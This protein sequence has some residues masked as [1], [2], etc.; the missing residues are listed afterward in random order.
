MKMWALVVVVFV[1][2]ITASQAGKANH[3]HYELVP[4]VIAELDGESINSGGGWYSSENIAA[5]ARGMIGQTG[6]VVFAVSGTQYDQVKASKTRIRE[7][8]DYRGTNDI[9]PK[10]QMISPTVRF[11]VSVVSENETENFDGNSVN[12]DASYSQEKTRT[13]VVFESLSLGGGLGGKIYRADAT[14]NFPTD[15]RIGS[16]DL[17]SFF[18]SKSGGEG[19]NYKKALENALRSIASQI[20]TDYQPEPMC[21]IDLFSD[22]KIR[23]EKDDIV[24]YREGQ[25]IARY[26]VIYKTESLIGVRARRERSVPR[27]GDDFNIVSN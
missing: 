27:H 14:A 11:S 16:Y 25:E 19:R 21:P 10:G 12:I 13:I 8:G 2:A 17:G 1:L 3:R 22:K 20:A 7:S 9:A 18:A 6:F 26:E 4:V 5:T 23:S 24:F 15:L